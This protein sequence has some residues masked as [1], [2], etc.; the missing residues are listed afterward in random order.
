MADLMDLDV[1]HHK[2]VR[3]LALFNPMLTK[4]YGLKAL[5]AIVVLIVG[6]AGQIP[7]SFLPNLKPSWA[8]LAPGSCSIKTNLK[9]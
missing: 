9:E 4:T 5:G 3:N 6:V 8:L 7:A 1:L 2:L